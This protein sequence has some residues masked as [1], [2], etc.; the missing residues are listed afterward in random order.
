MALQLWEGMW[1]R[2]DETK[3]GECTSSLCCSVSYVTGANIAEQK[4][5]INADNVH[6]DKYS[7]SIFFSTALHLSKLFFSCCV[8]GNLIAMNQILDALQ[9]LDTWALY[10]INHGLSNRV[11]D[12]VMPQITTNA[13][14]TPIY[15]VGLVGLFV[16]GARTWNSGGR[17]LVVCAAI[18]IVGIAIL[19]QTGHRFLKEVIG[20]PRPYMVL[21]DIHKLVGSGGGS[22]PSNHAMNNSFVA[23]ILS[24]WFP[25]LRH[26]WWGIAVLIMFTRPYCG[27]HYPS[28]ILGGYLFGYGAAA[29][30]LRYLRTRWP[31]LLIAPPPR[32]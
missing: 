21:A 10:A 23:A 2:Y 29:L 31:Q 1:G 28:D 20:R 22:F 27:V 7:P 5:H 12:A 8:A 26:L 6:V 14:W 24:A 4:C 13:F 19:D 15:V 11:L 9:W 25:R 18:M 17:R 32:L 3:R 16:Q 30:T